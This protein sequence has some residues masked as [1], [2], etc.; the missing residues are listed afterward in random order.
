MLG[1]LVTLFAGLSSIFKTRAALQLE[2]LAPRHQ[3]S[4]LHRS[5][6]RPKLT[7][8]DRFLWARLCG[9]WT[10]WRSAI[11]FVKPETVIAWHRQGFRLFWTWKVRAGHP[12]RPAISLEIR[13]LIRQMSRENPTWGAPRIH[14]E[15]LKLGVD[16]GETSVSKY[17]VRVRKPVVRKK[18]STEWNQ[19]FVIMG[20][21]HV[22]RRYGMGTGD[23]NHVIMA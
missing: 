9:I 6:R 4:V 3:L 17:L 16:I 12:G 7:T 23:W 11:L 19:Q 10:D 21:E 20:Q 8:F 15:L 1:V 2:N 14:G 13:D 22:T 5:V 18:P